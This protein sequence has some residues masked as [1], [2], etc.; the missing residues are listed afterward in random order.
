MTLGHLSLNAHV[1]TWI[2]DV[3][4]FWKAVPVFVKHLRR[5]ENVSPDIYKEADA[6]IELSHRLFY[7]P[8]S[9]KLRE[10]DREKI[11]QLREQTKSLSN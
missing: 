11:N 2:E 4:R 5:E 10:L 3:C 6:S 9:V 7:F 1:D 8:E